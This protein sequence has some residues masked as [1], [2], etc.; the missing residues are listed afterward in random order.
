MKKYL[1][2]M[3]TAVML[4]CCL[5]GCE[6]STPAAPGTTQPAPEAAGPAIP[7]QLTITTSEWQGIDMFQ[8]DSWYSM[9]C[10]HADTILAWGPDGSALPNIA[11]NSVWSEDGLT[12]TLTFPEGMYYCTG[13]QLEPEDVI[14]SLE[15]GKELS[16]WADGYASIESM[17]IDGRDVILHLSEYQADIE[18]N[19]MS[20]FIGV[21]DKDELDTMSNEELLF[22]CHPYG[23]YY[24][25][26][27]VPGAY[28]TLKANPGYKTHNPLVQN[29]GKVPVETINLVM[30][31]EDFTYYTGLLNGDYDVLDSAPADYLE[32]LGASEDVVLVESAEASVQYCEFNIS[33]PFFAD[34][35]VREAVIRA[36]DRDKATAY[37]NAYNKATYCL[38]QKNCLNYSEEA[39]EYYKEHYGYDPEAAKALM[40]EAGWADTDGDGWLDKD[41]VK[42]FFT[43]SCRDTDSSKVVVQSITEDLAA[44][45]IDM[46]ITTQNWAYVNQEVREGTCDIG[47]L[48]LGWSE[49]MLL[50][51]NFC[52]RSEIAAA[53]SNLDLPGYLE[54]VAKAKTTVDYDERTKIIRDIQI[55]LFDYCT[56]MPLTCGTDYRCWSSKLDGVVY[57]LNGGF[58]LND[59]HYAG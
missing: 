46:D 13:E 34:K 38:V 41:G 50:L 44:I 54:M 57:T 21:I 36:Y 2:L 18:F 12:W 37:S 4:L 56:I 42:A 5:T 35:R 49:P 1:A 3:L 43:F 27:Y 7:E 15:H 58:W 51:N 17:E 16:T 47:Y 23:A 22:G 20:G 31:G 40:A 52:N 6:S 14:A 53:N 39:E 48:N 45:G 9:Q 30:G 11:S 32:E 24:V 19:F 55:K 29:K 28:V 26:E 33:K 25:E 10:L 8:C 59:V